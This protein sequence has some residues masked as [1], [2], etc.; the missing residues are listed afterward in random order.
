[1]GW[2]LTLGRIDGIKV[3]VHVTFILFLAW[4]GASFWQ[5]GG[6]QA[7]VQGLAYIVGRLRQFAEETPEDPSLY[8]A[9]LLIEL[10]VRG[11]SF[12]HWQKAQSPA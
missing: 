11:E 10:S 3:R 6:P 7:A 8:P 5:S 4:I 9:R 1:M 2:S 12:A